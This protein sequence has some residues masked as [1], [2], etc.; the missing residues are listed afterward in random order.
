MVQQVAEAKPS[1]RLDLSTTLRG[2]WLADS[3]DSFGATSVRDRTGRSGKHAG[4]Q[5]EFRARRVLVPNR[6]KLD[7]GGDILMKG[8]F[9]LAAPN[10]PKT[11]DVHYGYFEFSALF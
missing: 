10:A 5:I 11:G 1:G 3:T 8:H 9:L 6:L 4:T 2:L 7:I